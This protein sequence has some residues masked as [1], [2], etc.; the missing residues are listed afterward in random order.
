[1]PSAKLSP[2]VLSIALFSLLA[3]GS[4]LER[5][6]VS[7]AGLRG[8]VKRCVESTT[9]LSDGNIPERTSTMTT[10]Y[11]P[12]GYRL[13]ERSGYSVTKYTYEPAGRLVKSEIR[14]EGSD[15]SEFVSLYSYDAK[16]RPT[17]IASPTGKSFLN[18]EYDENGG[19]RRIEHFPTLEPGTAVAGSPWEGGALPL[20]PPSGGT[21]I[22]IYD[23]KDRP[24]EAQATDAE[25]HLI[26]RLMRTYD[27]DG[28]ILADKLY[29]QETEAAI[30]QDI[31]G[32]LNDAQKRAIAK[33]MGKAF[34][35]GEAAYQYDTEGHLLEKK[36]TGGAFGDE[37]TTYIYNEH[38][39]VT[40]ERS[41]HLMSPEVGVEYGMTQEGKMIPV[42]PPRKPEGSH[43]EIRYTYEYDSHGNW[44]K[45]TT[46]ARYDPKGEFL[47]TVIVERTLSYYE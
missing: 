33:F 11:S 4:D 20:A 24:V 10:V 34:G 16:G 27:K 21:L 8:P 31:A 32:Q 36:V 25:G 5:N 13:E 17:G 2:A 22:T 7:D 30:P 28:R 47:T 19:K 6:R 14:N 37:I 46:I 39:D 42:S 12:T 26:V 45:K 41:A 35:S 44:T 15:G 43:S 40:E 3:S 1:L 29:P 38:A 18:Y 9:Y 23:D